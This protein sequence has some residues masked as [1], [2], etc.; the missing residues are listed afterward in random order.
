MTAAFSLSNLDAVLLSTLYAGHAPSWAIRAIAAASFLGSGWMMIALLPG[1]AVRKLRTYTVCLVATL[2]LTSALVAAVKTLIGR[3]RPCYAEASVRALMSAPP[4]DCSLP[5]G[6]AAGTFA[7]AAFLCAVFGAR[8]GVPALLLAVAVAA[9]R[10]ALGVHYP[11]DVLAGALL[12]GLIG[13]LAGLTSQNASRR[14]ARAV[15]E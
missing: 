15:V 3:V 8:A 6:H 7:F 12:G 13:L 5:S 14:V 1:I 9:S 11:T 2:L 4:T 10:V